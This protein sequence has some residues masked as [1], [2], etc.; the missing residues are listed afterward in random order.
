MFHVDQVNFSMNIAFIGKCTKVTA[1]IFLCF[2]SRIANAVDF[3]NQTLSTSQLTEILLTSGGDS[4]IFRKCTFLTGPNKL[5]YL[6]SGYGLSLVR[7]NVKFEECS[8]GSEMGLLELKTFELNAFEFQS[9]LYFIK[10]KGD[11]TLSQSV[12]KSLHLRECEFNKLTFSSCTIM[13]QNSGSE[14]F[15]VGSDIKELTLSYC[16]VISDTGF[17]FSNSN[18]GILTF[19][20]SDFSNI[21][22][23]GG[24]AYLHSSDFVDFFHLNIDQWVV[25]DSN[26]DLALSL[27]FTNFDKSIE[28]NRNT[29]RR[30]IHIQKIKIPSDDSY[31]NYNDIKGKIVDIY[32]GTDTTYE[33]LSYS[34]VED[35]DEHFSSYYAQTGYTGDYKEVL[36]F[37]SRLLSVF[38]ANSD[39]DAK[40]WCYKKLKDIEKNASQFNYGK[41]KTIDAFFQWRMNEFLETFCDYGTNPVKSLVFSFYWILFFCVVYIFFPSEEDNLSFK[42]LFRAVQLY[43]DHFSEKA[44]ESLSRT[45]KENEEVNDLNR[46]KTSLHENKEKLPPAVYYFGRPLY[47]IALFLARVKARIV[48][49]VEFNVYH[50]WH[51]LSF[52]KKMKTSGL[53][54]LSL[55]GFLLWGLIMRLLNAVALSMN[56]FVTLGYG[57]IE[58]SGVAR[59]FC[60]LEGIVGWFLLSIFSVSLI[61]QILQ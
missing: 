17:S 8:F 29:F 20:N 35:F 33:T 36:A 50:D 39:L 13:Y 47:H 26:F 31:I 1:F 61:G 12:I 5:S 37:Y 10:C 16:A 32:K 2:F 38:D 40:N 7:A 49:F 3:R 56:A 48:D 51:T 45:R 22:P 42:K 18:I 4:I 57:E 9:S 21:S 27:Q 46:F 52:W 41:T 43:I 59:Y 24:K 11:L 28:M 15:V 19:S 25:T 14:F 60:V 23:Y 30:V 54:S 6:F 55:L 53:I 34:K 44:G 58:A